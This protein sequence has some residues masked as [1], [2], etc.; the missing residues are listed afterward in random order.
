MNFS[1]LIRWTLVVLVGLVFV[2]CSGAMKNDSSIKGK[3]K[4]EKQAKARGA[5]KAAKGAKGLMAVTCTI[6]GDTREIQVVPYDSGCVVNYTKAGTTANPA[7]SRKG[8]AYCENVAKR[9][10]SNLESA[11]FT[12]K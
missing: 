2:G 12:C 11:G 8:M 9:I 7:Q 1:S 6:G 4:S 5:M 10:Q 3:A